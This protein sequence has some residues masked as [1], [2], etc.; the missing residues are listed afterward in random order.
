MDITMPTQLVSSVGGEGFRYLLLESGYSLCSATSSAFSALLSRPLPAVQR[1]IGP[2]KLSEALQVLAGLTWRLKVDEVN[3]EVYFELRDQYRSF[4]APARVIT[5]PAPRGVPV[6][7]TSGTPASLPVPPIAA[8]VASSTAPRNPF[9]ALTVDKPQ[10]SQSASGTAAAN[11]KST[12]V[13]A[14][15]VGIPEK[16]APASM[17]RSSTALLTTVNPSSSRPVRPVTTLPPALPVDSHVSPT[18]A[19]VTVF[20]VGQT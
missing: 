8:V 19:P 1:D 15:A 20:P 3:G 7:R 18:G 10:V 16:T 5:S 2:L 6:T 13:L 9:A 12:S 17:V 14:P 11:T 4:S